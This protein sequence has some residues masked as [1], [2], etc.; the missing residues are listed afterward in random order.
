VLYNLGA[1]DLEIMK[2]SALLINTSRGPL[3]NETAL[4]ETLRKGRIRGA[5]L[6][7]FEIE[8]LPVDS[9]RR[10]EEWR[11]EGK[12]NVFLTPHMGYV[13]EGVLN[14]WYEETAEN[15]ERWLEGKDL[16]YRLN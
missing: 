7:V 6:G 13:E 10:S 4:L 16:L 12:S 14:T 5:A 3:I 1:K 8:P 2:E 9:S 11:K 15:L